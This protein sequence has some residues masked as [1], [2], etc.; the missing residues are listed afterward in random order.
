M[1]YLSTGWLQHTCFVYCFLIKWQHFLVKVPYGISCKQEILVTNTGGLICYTST[2]FILPQWITRWDFVDNIYVN[3]LLIYLRLH[4][5]FR[6]KIVISVLLFS[7]KMLHVSKHNGFPN[8]CAKLVNLHYIITL[9]IKSKSNYKRMLGGYQ[10][11][12]YVLLCH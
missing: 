10:K 3:F 4:F 5:F 1:F 11:Y 8:L 9:E 12:N 6:S 2:I 7:N